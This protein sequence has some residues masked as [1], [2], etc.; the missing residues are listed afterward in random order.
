LIFF[1]EVS[2][3]LMGSKSTKRFRIQA[4]TF[5]ST[6]STC[7]SNGLSIN[8]FDSMKM[9][10]SETTVMGNYLMLILLPVFSVYWPHFFYLEEIKLII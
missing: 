6:P 4:D 7:M 8:P 1:P 3:P 10:K 9:T 2:D 5:L